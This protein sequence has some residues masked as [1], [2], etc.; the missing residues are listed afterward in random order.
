MMMKN[1]LF[2]LLFFYAAGISA[3]V[4]VNT[5]GSLPDNSAMLDIKSTT[6]GMLVPRM[7]TAQRTAIATPA[8]GLL[9]FDNS[10]NSFWFYG[11]AAW[12]EITTGSSG[13]NV[14]GNSGTDTT[15]NFIGTT[16]NLPLAFRVNNQA[17]GKIDPVLSNTALGYQSLVL[18]TT[19]NS[20]V[21]LGASTL[22]NNVSGTFN[23]AVGINSL[24]NN[25]SGIYNTGVGTRSLQFTTGDYNTATGASAL[26][27]NTTGIYN[28]AMGYGAIGGPNTGAANTGIGA[29][30]LSSNTSGSSNT[31]VGASSLIFNTTGDYNTAIG[32]SAL[33]INETGHYNTASGWSSLMGNSTGNGNTANGYA[34]LNANS[35]GELNTADGLKALYH[36]NHGSHNTACGANALFNNVGGFGNTA[37]GNSA[38][39]NNGIGIENTAIGDQ[40]LSNNLGG[41]FNIAIGFASGT[42]DYAPNIYNTVSIG[43]NDYLNGYQNQVFLGNTSTAWIGGKVTWSTFSDARI[44]NNINSDVVGLAFITRLKPVTY[45]ISNRAIVSITGNK[46][47]ADFPG[48]NDNEKV[49]YSG[50]IA[51]DVEQAAKASGYDFSGYTAPR[52]DKDLYTLSYEQFVVPLVKSVQELNSVNEAQKVTNEELKS[53]INEL[54]VQHEKLLQRIEKLENK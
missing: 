8:A 24:Y 29:Q 23:T 2:I 11:A 42:A 13:W 22:Y 9:V 54:K 48:K 37:L 32:E 26:R 12:K 6:K 43:N 47:T 17:S 38:L 51:Q 28:T 36:N 7:T 21:A 53:T 45:H 27:F 19:G 34:A 25:I 41:S 35:D 52:N 33:K 14:T 15:V 46:E 39:Y 10:T 50:F 4:A 31:A 1:L 20:N 49:K 5:D 18:N 40:A 3:Q 44:K 30:A 16:D